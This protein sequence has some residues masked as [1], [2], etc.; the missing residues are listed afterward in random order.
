MI[1]VN[2]K[3]VP[4]GASKVDAAIFPG[5]QGGPHENHIAAVAYQLKQVLGTSFQK[6]RREIEFLSCAAMCSRIAATDGLSA[7]VVFGQIIL[8]LRAW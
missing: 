3:R 1:F 2:T 4:D 6:D 5:L 7:S 8:S